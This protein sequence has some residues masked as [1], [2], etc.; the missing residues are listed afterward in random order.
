VI[1]CLLIPIISNAEPLI[2]ED[3]CF[4]S[5]VFE[6]PSGIRVMNS[7]VDTGI[8]VTL[9]TGTK[10]ILKDGFVAHNGAAFHAIVDRSHFCNDIDWGTDWEQEKTVP[11]WETPGLIDDIDEYDGELTIK[12]ETFDMCRAHVSGMRCMVMVGGGHG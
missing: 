7:N 11:L 3:T 4:V 10:I 6:Y 5:G 9:R 1:I 8:N 12:E 2:I